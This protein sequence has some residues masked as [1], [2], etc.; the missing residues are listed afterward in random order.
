MPR[1]TR[2]RALAEILI[3]ENIRGAA[4]DALASEYSVVTEPELWKD[5]A[6]LVKALDGAKALII[7]NQTKVTAELLAAAPSLEVIGRAGVGLDNVDV[8]ACTKAGVQVVS[9]PEQNAISVAE[10]AIGLMLSLARMI[11]AADIDTKAGGWSR[12]RF[13]GVELWGKTLGILGAGKI[14]FLTAMRAKAF[15][16]KIVAYDPFV[17]QDSVY[18]AEIG[19]ELLPLE[20]VLAQS[21]FVS[22]HM[23]ATSKTNGMLDAGCF[24]KMKKTAFF[25]NTSRG[26][27]V[28]ETDLV[29]ALKAK[30]IAGAALDVRAKEPPV[31]GE[32]ETLDNIL[33]V[34]HIAAL[35]NEAQDRVTRSICE[36]VAAVLRGERPSNPVN[37][38]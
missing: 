13:T 21:D 8:A 10:L 16:M 18:L 32:L 35:T 9:T 15:G 37:K 36:D 31:K 38:V 27:V 29:A 20:D 2:C 7:R 28:N 14:G 24:S 6:A 11:P 25:V 3:S 33:L 5:T 12:Q 19:A 30:T 22:C 17:S 23:P 34:P 4:V 1:S 26:E